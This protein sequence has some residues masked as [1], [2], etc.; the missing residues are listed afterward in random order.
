MIDQIGRLY[1]KATNFAVVRVDGATADIIDS[2]DL[3]VLAGSFNPLHRGHTGLLEAA[4]RTTGRTGVFEISIENVDKP[5][6]PRVELEKRLIQFRDVADVI[7]TRA[8]LFSDKAELLPGTWFVI[9]YDTAVRLLD[10][11]YH[12]DGTALA[13]LR[14]LYASGLK[15]IVAGRVGEDGQF[16]GVESL[17]VPGEL[18]EMFVGIPETEFR[19]DIS[20]TEL[21][22]Q[23]PR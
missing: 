22:K 8:R 7:V 9:G 21:R 12:Q 20:S 23:S 11:R 14:R 6:L 10:D 2:G 4:E 16:R 17:S 15:F 5:D 19:E 13:D 3:V 1:S 18:M